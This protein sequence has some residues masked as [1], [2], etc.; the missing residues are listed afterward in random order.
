MRSC[1]LRRRSP[2]STMTTSHLA[3]RSRKQWR[4]RISSTGGQRRFVPSLRWRK[5]QAGEKEQVKLR[6]TSPQ[7]RS[8]D[9]RDL[10]LSYFLDMDDGTTVPIEVM[11]GISALLWA[12]PPSAPLSLNLVKRGIGAE[13]LVVLGRAMTPTLTLLDLGHSDCA[14]NGHDNTGI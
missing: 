1:R 5:L 14:N 11:H 3:R 7:S 6:D 10:W 8:C 4:W 13:G 2:R 9:R 12:R